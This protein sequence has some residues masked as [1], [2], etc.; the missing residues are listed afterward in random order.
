L[1][2]D[3]DGIVTFTAGEEV[4]L[5]CPGNNNYL[6]FA[7]SGT[8]TV[9]ATC[10]SGTTFYIN[11]I[12]YNFSDFA[13]KSYPQHTAR[14]SGSKCYD[15]TK[16]HTEVGFKVES[17]FYKIIDICFDD[18]LFNPLYS[19]FTL[20]SG[21]GGYQSGFPRPDFVKDN[22]YPG[23]PVDDLYT[24]NKQRQTI[25]NTLGSTLL[26]DKYIDESSDYFLIRGHLTANADFVYG[27]QHR[28]TFHFIN[29]APQWQTINGKNW[30]S[31]EMSVR[32]YAD[33]NKLNLDV[34]TG[35]YG[36]ATLPNVNGTET[37]L[38]LYVDN[39]NNK[40]IPVPKL[41]WKAVYNSKTQA[42]IVFVGINNPYLSNAEE[43]YLICKDV[44]SKISWLQWDQKNI[45]KGYSY[46]CDVNEF[47]STVDTLPELPVSSLLI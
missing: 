15:G 7:G 44:C 22:F 1:P 47:R 27:S 21:I 3:A 35:T 6:S 9:L 24:R 18:I 25:S 20:V 34:Y 13:C 5:A 39:N 31:L 10:K 29:V 33:K 41:F 2:E 19:K 30:N 17:D 43:D 14:K 11:S 36:V 45:K 32:T 26:G 23:I 16:S 42:G 12:S 37:E 4:L 28:A 40:G 8:R 38:H 46:C